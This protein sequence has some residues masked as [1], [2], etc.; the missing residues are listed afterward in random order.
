MKTRSID[1]ARIVWLPLWAALAWCVVCGGCRS[2][3][4]AEL[5]PIAPEKERADPLARYASLVRIANVAIPTGAVTSAF[6]L[7]PGEGDIVIGGSDASVWVLPTN[8]G[9]PH[10]LVGHSEPIHR[11][12]YTQDGQTLVT[13]G[14]D[15]R[16]IAWDIAQ[17]RPIHEVRAHSRD[18]RALS[19]SPDSA[20]LATG[21]EDSNVHLW[22]M[23][24][25]DRIHAFTAHTKAVQD[26]L[27]SADGQTLVSSGNDSQIRRWDIKKK[28]NI[29][30]GISVGHT[31]KRL[32]W[33]TDGRY[34]IAAGGQGNLTWLDANKW[35]VS[36]THRQRSSATIKSLDVSPDGLIATGN[37]QGLVA[38]WST[39]PKQNTPSIGLFKAHQ[40]AVL[41]IRFEAKGTLLTLGA[42]GTVNRW[43]TDDGTP[44]ENAPNLPPFNGTCRSVAL[45]PTVPQAVAASGTRLFLFQADEPHVAP[46][47]RDLGP[48][49][50][51]ALQF[52][53]PNHQIAV[54]R[55]TGQ[56]WI[57]GCDRY[58]CTEERLD[59]LKG[60]IRHLHHR[61]EK[62]ALWVAGDTPQIVEY[63][64]ENWQETRRVDYHKS[65]I[66]ALDIDPSG[67]WLAST[68][69]DHVTYV[70]DLDATAKIPKAENAELDPGLWRLRGHTISHLAF[71]TTGEHLATVQEQRLVTVYHIPTRTQFED[72]RVHSRRIQGM[73]YH[74]TD[75]VLITVDTLGT[76]RVVDAVSG[77]V[78]VTGDAGRGKPTGLDVGNNGL[79]IIT[80]GLDPN[81]SVKVF[82]IPEVE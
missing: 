63:S 27:F 65:R 68:E 4:D 73:S 6:A 35:S 16:W 48:G 74:P 47:T 20:L 36:A 82:Q 3:S 49:G 62:K 33:T 81:G 28:K 59:V 66:I 19:V 5:L 80:G 2:N 12:V 77:S 70:Q 11:A 32:A 60:S 29:G 23:Q 30:G 69:H 42:D 72:I 78:L 7:A 53:T 51:S 38:L 46:I 57:Q 67:R 39:D 41:A 26:V 76:V 17:E 56:V 50:I 52:V 9:V 13:A 44:G 8:T 24:S 71:D 37:S 55:D 79:S 54:G 14:E 22:R 1:C 64:T 31:V 25:G 15:N 40:G 18:I 43:N 75:P 61:E 10:V 45:H 34:L 21:S 58:E